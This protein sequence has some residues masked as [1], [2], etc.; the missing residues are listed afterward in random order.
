MS[1]LC[2]KYVALS[3]FEILATIPTTQSRMPQAKMGTHASAMLSHFGLGKAALRTHGLV[4]ACGGL[5][6][7]G[8]ICV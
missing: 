3:R 7:L 4:F 1:V 2:L 8:L 5:Q 6:N